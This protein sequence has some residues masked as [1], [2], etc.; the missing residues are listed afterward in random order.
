MIDPFAEGVANPASHID[1]T[2]SELSLASELDKA[3]IH[4]KNAETGHQ[5]AQTWEVYSH[6]GLRVCAAVFVAVLLW[7]WM[8]FLFDSVDYY[9]SQMKELKQEI[10]SEVMLAVIGAG[11]TIVGLMG[12][13][14]KGLFKSN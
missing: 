12:F 1:A 8:S 9:F 3:E 4:R 2:T 14:L 13:I 5:K 11:A 6:I 7:V 10:P